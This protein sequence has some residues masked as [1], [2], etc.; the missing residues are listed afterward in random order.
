MN[1]VA[2]FYRELV[3][4]LSERLRNGERDIDALGGAGQGQD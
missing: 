1:K 3:S 2:Q 4:T